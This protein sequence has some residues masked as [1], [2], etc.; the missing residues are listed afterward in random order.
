MHQLNWAVVNLHHLVGLI[1]FL[2]YYKYCQIVFT[3][4]K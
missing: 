4:I 2:S 3:A 1:I